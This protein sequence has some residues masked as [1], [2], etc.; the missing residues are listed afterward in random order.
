MFRHEGPARSARH[1]GILAGY[2]A[3]VAGFVNAAG[4]VLLGAFTSHVTGNVGRMS[5]GLVRGDYVGAAAA[6]VL[7]LLFLCGAVVAS[8]L[9]ETSLFRRTATAYGVALLVQAVALSMFV[10]DGLSGVLSFAMGMQNSLVTRLS[11]SVVR[12]THLTGVVTDL[13]IEF[14][15]WV[16]WRW[17]RLRHSA[18]TTADRSPASRPIPARSLL[19]VTI[20]VA[21]AA[22]GIGG[23]ATA[24]A[25][26][27]RAIWIPAA[28]IFAA[29]I[30][31]F[32][33]GTR[34]PPN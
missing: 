2:L 7:V 4:V 20:V 26:G 15:R 1:N 21:F 16:R 5:V 12:T 13:G 19:L 28:A 24:P 17:N 29:A 22:G 25:W 30:Y 31:A 34:R 8:L 9:V 32:V 23:A 11:G 10:S 18:Q 3:F 6:S 33:T 14:A 27:T